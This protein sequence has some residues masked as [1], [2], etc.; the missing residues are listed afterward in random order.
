MRNLFSNSLR[1]QTLHPRT[2]QQ[3]PK[4]RSYGRFVDLVSY[5]FQMKMRKLGSVINGY[6]EVSTVHG[7]QYA[8]S[9]AGAVVDRIL[10]NKF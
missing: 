2:I 7:V 8:L 6:G 3:D 4:L 9:K 1:D 10:I 5:N